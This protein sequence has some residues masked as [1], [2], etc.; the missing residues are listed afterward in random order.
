MSLTRSIRRTSVTRSTT[1]APLSRRSLSRRSCATRWL[2]LS[3]LAFPF[4][5]A[6]AAG[7]GART[8][9]NIPPPAPPEPECLVDSDCPGVDDLCKPVFCRLFEPSPADAGPAQPDAGPA[10][11]DA[12][13]VRRGGECVALTPVDCDDD[14]ACTR[15]VCEPST[16]ECSH[17]PAT[18]D[19]DGDGYRAPLPG[20][21]PSDPLSCGDDCDDASAAAHPGGIE[22]CDGVDNDCDGTIDNGA[23]FVPLDADA[24]RL[25]GDIAPAGSGGLAWSGTSYAAIYSGTSQGFSMYRSMVSAEGV[26]LAPGEEVIT[27]RNGDASGGP[28][29]WVGDRYGVAWQDRRDGDYEVYFSLLDENGAKVEGGDKRLSNAPGFSINVTLAWNGAEFTAVWQD[30]RNGLFDL[31]AQRLDVGGNPIGENVQLTDSSSTGQGNEAPSVAAGTNGIGVAWTS[32][33][34]TTHVIQFQT[35]TAEL[36]PL[37]PVVF[38]TN[39]GSDAVYPTIVWNKDRYVVAWFDKTASPKGIYAAALSE[40]G[41]VLTQPKPISSPGAFRSRYPFLR[42]LGDR[43]LAIYSDDRDRNNGYELYAVMVSGALDRISAEQRLTFSGRDSVYPVA[44]F[45]P[46]GDVGILFRDDRDGGEHHVF[47]TRLGCI[48]GES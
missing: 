17:G 3:V 2:L 18:L 15:D 9:L 46:D 42:P 16:G 33:D 22:I 8:G 20:T 37:S 30:E 24:T 34:A 23:R 11:P 27:P 25:S 45:G 13:P 10:Q 4:G 26:P 29:V 31:F 41:A 47:F 39:G 21:L 12:G 28:I 19:S 36:E 48:A 6:L 1:P 5:G 43:V 14:D 7:C 40:D 44:A 38:L 35:F 32:G